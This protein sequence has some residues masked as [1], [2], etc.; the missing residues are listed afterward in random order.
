MNQTLTYDPLMQCLVVL[1]KL[2]NKPASAESLAHGLPFDPNDE[3][4][5]LFS[6]DK[7]KA[8]FSRAAA[9]AG[10]ISRLQER[11]LHEIPSVVLPVI[12]VLRDDNACVLTEISQEQGVA[13]IIVPSVDEAPMEIELEKLAEEYLGYV[14]FLKRKY[15][16]FG[17]DKRTER[18]PRRGS[19]FFGTMFKFKG[20]YG[21]VF[22]GTLLINL[23]VVAGPLFTMNVYDR[24]IPHNAIDTLWVLASGIFLIY[25]FDL[26]LKYI[27]TAFLETAAKKSDI[28]LSSMLFEQAL[29]LKLENKPRSVGSFTSNIKD[30][31]GIRSFFASSAITAFIELPFAVIFLLVIYSI[32]D[33]MVFIPLAVIAVILVVSLSMKSTIYKIVASTHEAAARRNGILVEALANLETIKAFNASGSMQ[34]HWEESTGDIASKTLRSRKRSTTLSTITAFLSQFGSVAI[35]VLGV[36]L[37]RAGELSMG[38]L[39]AI[40]MLSSRSIA[41]MSQVVSLLSNFEQMK[42]GLESLNELMKLEVERP[43]QKQFIRRPAFKGE[44]EFKGV[45]FCYP[46]E[47]KTALSNVS[48]HLKPGEKVGIIGQVG[49]GKSTVSKIL[50]G[51]YEASEGAVF[52]DGLDVKQIDPVDLRHN[53]SYVP[54]DVVLFSG[55][56]RDNIT[57]KSP[58]AGDQAIIA[59][60][61]IGRV[62]IFT[63]RHPMGMDMQVGERGFNLSGG[64]RQSVALARSFIQESPIV[65]LD[66]PTNSMDFNT[67]VPVIANLKTTIQEKTTIIITHKPTILEVV[68]RIIVMD[69]GRVVMDGPKDEVLA[70]LGGKSP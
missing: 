43:E 45:S 53:F 24:I 3:K 51:F 37:I 6:V 48:F 68:D 61:N 55:T 35:V 57:I 22:L 47:Q 19:W 50:L 63:D 29:N 42:A 11:Q 41:P 34:W 65:L 18:R 9:K 5:R 2:N 49:S 52:I 31:D 38:G 14:F 62:N 54:Q 39:I 36:Y 44:I 25:L 12:L 32:N 64:Q 8:N 4:Q 1:T 13:Q 70:R 28:I 30:F 33:T 10:F 16:G 26:V 66:E 40:N 69:D 20:I 27:R 56:V 58:H 60:A 7:P 46:D 17:Q 59:A 21:R 15:E 67:E 23:F